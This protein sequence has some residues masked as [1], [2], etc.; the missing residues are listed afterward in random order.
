MSRLKLLVT[1]ITL[2]LLAGCGPTIV[3][4]YHAPASAE[5]RVCIAQCSNQKNYCQQ[6]QNNQHNQCVNQYSLMM[7]NYNSCVESKGKNCVMPQ[8]CPPAN[9]WQ[10]EQGY[11]DCFTVCGGTVTSR[12]V[13]K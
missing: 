2:G 13:E 10:C 4:D 12:E 11:R 6:T 1:A 5:G 9:T 3:Y 8:Y 7:Q